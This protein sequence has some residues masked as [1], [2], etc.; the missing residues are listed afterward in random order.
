[1]VMPYPQWWFSSSFLRF[2]LLSPDYYCKIKINI[3]SRSMQ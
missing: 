1:L 2:A 3:I